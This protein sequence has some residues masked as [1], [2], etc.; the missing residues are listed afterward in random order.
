[1]NLQSDTEAGQVITKYTLSG[2]EFESCGTVAEHSEEMFQLCLSGDRPAEPYSEN[3]Q[4]CII[5]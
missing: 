4:I 5:T 1:M 2:T 3:Q